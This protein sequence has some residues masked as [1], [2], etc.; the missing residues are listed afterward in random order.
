MSV[1]RTAADRA[2][3][4]SRFEDRIVF[5][6]GAGSGIGQATAIRLAAEGAFLYITDLDDH[7]LKDTAAQCAE[8]GADVATQA[9]DVA[10]EASVTAAVD[11]CISS[12]GRMHCLCNAAGA[13][14][15]GDLE[16]TTLEQFRLLVD[17]NLLGTFL[18]TRAAMRHLVETR[19]NIV[20]ISS[21]AAVEGVGLAAAYGATKGGVSSFSRGV[22]AEFGA[23]GVRCNTIVPG[24]IAPA[25]M[26]GEHVPTSVDLWVTGRHEPISGTPPLARIASVVAMVAS[27][28]GAHLNGAEIRVDGGW[29]TALGPSQ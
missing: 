5:V 8:H 1:D 22:A 15:F 19:G 16:K 12:F 28:D 20:N 3:A 25:R 4:S 14:V 18:T 29:L 7:G 26:A 2:A 9:M 21:T 17:V 23:R 27:D 10:D 13:V 24:S 11:A 6:T